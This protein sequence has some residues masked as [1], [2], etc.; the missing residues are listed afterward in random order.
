MELLWFL[1]V[2]TAALYIFRNPKDL[3][4]ITYNHHAPLQIEGR[5]LQFQFGG[6]TIVGKTVPTVSFKNRNKKQRQQKFHTFF[7]FGIFVVGQG[8]FS[9]DVGLPLAMYL[10]AGAKRVCLP[11]WPCSK[12]QCRFCS[13]SDV[14]LWRV[15]TDFIVVSGC[16]W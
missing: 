15:R 8:G 13:H 5:T 11:F 3:L 12:T 16:N 6:R 7:P 1:E 14:S 4:F 2:D 9:T 10:I